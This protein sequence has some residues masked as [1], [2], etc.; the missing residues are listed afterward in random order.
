MKDYLEDVLKAIR[1][2]F[3]REAAFEWFVVV[4]AGL[5]VR[6]DTFG[7]SSI[8]RA[9]L[10]TPVCYPSLLHFFHS[11][12]WSAESLLKCWWQWLKKEE[13]AFR[14]G[15]HIVL[16]GDHTKT[17]KDGRRIPQVTTL[18]Q[19]SET[20]S[21]P[22]F[23][24]G[25]H[26]ACLGLLVK[27]GKKLRAIG[28]WAEIHN[29]SIEET[30][31]T[32]IVM[33]AG[34]IARFMGSPAIL[35]LDAFFAVGP[36]FEAAAKYHGD[37]HI[38]TRAK[39]N[40]VAYLPPNK[41]NKNKPGRPR[42]YGKKLKMID[43]F[44][45]CPDKFNTTEAIV[46]KN[47]ETIRYLTLDLFWKP[48]QRLIRFILVETSRGKI[49]LI[50]S[51][52]SMTPVVAIELYCCRA[53]IET[54][55]NMLKNI[56]GGMCYRFWSKYLQPSSRKPSKKK[57][58]SPTSTRLE[59]TKN[60]FDAITKFLLVHLVVLGILQLLARRFGSEINLK[61]DCWLR[62]PCGELPSDF[63][64][65]TALSNMIMANLRRFNKDGI[66]QI[67]LKKQKQHDNTGLFE[68]VA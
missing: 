5:V 61:A 27:A 28:L 3:S 51:D 12:A 36:V 58:A 49:I 31:A 47:S 66:T 24:R 46:Y 13:T 38:L 32:R 26:W 41:P 39:K 34:Q 60:T 11:F 18:H 48:V 55:F 20:A 53:T 33:I 44:D 29:D 23:F 7:V 16:I 45:K 10:L 43:L 68:K 65:K 25:H 52:L 1:P 6:N 2:A 17:P 54:L 4:F 15:E 50:S 67:I 64:T 40:I 19:E 8:V 30:L 22:S 14:V 63:V 59:K 9:L 21:K 42:K 57:K 62:T 37:L 35:V 56:L